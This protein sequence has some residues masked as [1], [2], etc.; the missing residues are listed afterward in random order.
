MGYYRGERWQISYGPES[1]YGE[2]PVS[3]M[4]ATGI[5]GV[6]EGAN[7]P[8][9][10]FEHQEF[11][12]MNP[13]DRNYQI[14]YKG[15]ASST[16][17]IG[18][19]ILLDGTPL[20]LP[21]ADD[22]TTTGSTGAWVHTINET[23]NIR[24]IRLICTNYDNADSPDV[25]NRWFVGGKVNSATYKCDSG[26]MLMMSL[27]D[28]QFKMPYFWNTNPT[29]GLSP[30]YDADAEAQSLTLPTTEPYYFS[31]GVIKMKVP[32]LGMTEH[33]VSS[34][35]NFSIQVRNNLVPKYYIADNDEKVP[36]QIY[37]GR[38]QYTLSLTLDLIDQGTG[39]AFVKETPFL[40]LLN[41]GMDT[42]F[43][44]SAIDITFTRGTNDSIQFITPADGTPAAGAGEQGA[45]VVSAPFGINQEG[46]V[47]VT[48]QMKMR[49]LKVIVTDALAYNVRYPFGSAPA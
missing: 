43:K 13:A 7:L 31:Q 20:V 25:L 1:S 8:D 16:G 15:K 12:M 36:Y 4:T 38:R 5:F 6:F 45:L 22:I 42:T 37:E 26:G 49:N 17:S 23:Q 32:I 48:M 9:P 30:W 34:V 41:Q 19:I 46:V 47:G 28:M 33:T 3:G 40:E 39:S 18:N 44:G 29:T 21:L 27:D 10:S 14:A 11:W 24:S 2:T 35:K